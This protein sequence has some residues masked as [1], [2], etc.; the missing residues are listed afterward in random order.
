ME[1][2]LDIHLIINELQTSINSHD[3]LG[4]LLLKQHGSDE[5]VDIR[6]FGEGVEFLIT[7]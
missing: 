3:S 5:F 7:E 1:R 4:P 2:G 6:F